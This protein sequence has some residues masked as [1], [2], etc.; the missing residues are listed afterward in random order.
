MAGATDH[1]LIPR[2]RVKTDWVVELAVIIGKTARY[3]STPADARAAIAGYAVSNDVSELAFQ[4]ERGGR[5]DKGKSCET[6]SPR[7]PWLVTPDAV[8][9]P[10]SLRLRTWVD[11]QLYQDAST[12][13]MIFSVDYLVWHISQFMVLYPGDVIHMGTPAGVALGQPDPKPYVRHRS[14]VACEIDG[15]GRPRNVLRSARGREPP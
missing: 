4:L 6:F 7:G 11:G 10:Q 13:D 9:A 1:V 15:H 12:S 5:W 14:V 2:N 3:L 8:A